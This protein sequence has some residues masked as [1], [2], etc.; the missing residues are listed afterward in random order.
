VHT[1]SLELLKKVLD[2]LYMV[3]RKDAVLDYYSVTVTFFIK[4][5]F[6]R[7]KLYVNFLYTNIFLC[8]KGYA[9]QTCKV[10]KVYMGTKFI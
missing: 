2:V 8:N 10:T 3:H 6:I 4:V 9:G 1:S 7:Y 5:F